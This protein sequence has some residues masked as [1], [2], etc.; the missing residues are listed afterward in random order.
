[1]HGKLAWSMSHP[2]LMPMCRFITTPGHYSLYPTYVNI[3]DIL[4]WR[5][6]VTCRFSEKNETTYRPTNEDCLMRIVTT[7]DFC[8]ACL[9][10]LWY[11]LL[12]RVTLIDDVSVGCSSDG[13]RVLDL[14]LVPLAHLRTYSVDVEE[15][16]E[17]TWTKDGMEVPEFK[18]STTLVDDGG[19]LGSYVVKV[20][21]HTEEV[22]VDKERLLESYAAAVVTTK[23]P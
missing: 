17:I 11:A 7:P 12:R 16:Y 20:Q 4:I 14:D 19:A 21:Y 18:N 10:G 8:K 6:S 23:C 15:S 2:K 22:R 13:E 1:M 3:R 9:E 5:L